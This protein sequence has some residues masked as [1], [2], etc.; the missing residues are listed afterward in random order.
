MSLFND[1]LKNIKLIN[2][3]VFIIVSYVVLFVLGMFSFP[4]NEKLLSIAIVFYLIFILRDSLFDL[5]NDC[6]NVFSK[7]QLKYILLIVFANILFS[8]GMLYLSMVLI[9]YFPILSFLT[10]FYIPTMAL[11]SSL[12]LIGT[13]IS[14][15]IISP[16]C[17]E[18]IFRG[19]LLSKLKLFVPT[20]FAIAISSLLFGSL[21]SFGGIIS[22]V[23]FGICMAIL[24]LKT[25]N[26][27]VPIL[28]HFLNNLFAEIIRYL[29][30]NNFLFTNGYVITVV[31]I[32]AIVSAIILFASII[33]E[34]NKIK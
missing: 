24:Y 31:S 7:I 4:I 5:K 15:V 2:F 23:V 30:F 28:T 18:L 34:W 14:T 25:D 13:F 9:D 17:E 26:I 22:A 1:N 3:A 27:C 20:T 11:T 32:L 12:P 6:A 19:V 21:H 10:D 33:K 29:D 16:I 8:Y